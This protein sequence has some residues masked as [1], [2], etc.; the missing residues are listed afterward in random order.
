MCVSSCAQRGITQR[1]HSSDWRGRKNLWTLS[2]SSNWYSVQLLISGLSECI[3]E[4]S[5]LRFP[6]QV[7][8]LITFQC[9]PARK[10]LFSFPVRKMLLS[11]RKLTMPL[12]GHSE[13]VTL[14]FISRGAL[15]RLQWRNHWFLSL[16]FYIHITC[17][18]QRVRIRVS[19]SHSKACKLCTPKGAF[20]KPTW[21]LLFPRSCSSSRGWCAGGE[22][23]QYFGSRH[24]K[25]VWAFF[26]HG[27]VMC[28]YRSDCVFFSY[29]NLQPT[30]RTLLI[31]LKCPSV[32][33]EIG[34][35]WSLGCCVSWCLGGQ[36]RICWIS[37]WA[38]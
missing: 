4:P 30:C 19:N 26:L 14:C 36:L 3:C 28:R 37:V 35:K 20:F 5:R 2:L 38:C 1:L 22:P 7:Q 10:P 25:H 31:W 18:L 8:R 33:S 15:W 11:Q 34:L 24:G 16:S 21:R 13:S 32:L 12:L 17:L 27:W 29:W 6:S 23:G 9:L